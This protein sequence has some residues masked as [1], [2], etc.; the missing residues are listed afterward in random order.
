MQWRTIDGVTLD[1]LGEFNEL[2]KLIRG[3]LAPAMLLDYLRYYV[4][5][6]KRSAPPPLE[7][8]D[9]AGLLSGLRGNN[10]SMRLFGQEGSFSRVLVS[11]AMGSMSF[12]RAVSSRD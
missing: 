5:F 9:H 3:L 11:Q 6:G 4:L 7:A 12:M 1:P 2:E 8:Q 10:S